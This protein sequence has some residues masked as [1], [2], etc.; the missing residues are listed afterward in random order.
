MSA[1][2]FHWTSYSHFISGNHFK[3]KKIK[4][5]LACTWVMMSRLSPETLKQPYSSAWVI[6][7]H[8]IG[9][10]FGHNKCSYIFLSFIHFFFTRRKVKITKPSQVSTM[11]SVINEKMTVWKYGLSRPIKTSGPTQKKPN[12]QVRIL[13]LPWGWANSWFMA[14]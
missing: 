14:T 11:S 7:F 4:K 12:N 1:L 3:G 13:S 2:V 5:A 6:I 9:E 8:S 10:F